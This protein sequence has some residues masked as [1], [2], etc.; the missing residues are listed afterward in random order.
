MVQHMAE[1]VPV[2]GE[3]DTAAIMRAA[4]DYI[5]GWN[6][7]DAARMERSLHPHLAKRIFTATSPTHWPPGDRLDETSAQHLIQMTRRNSVAAQPRRDSWSP[8][9]TV[10]ILDR[11]ANA[12]SVKIWGDSDGEYAHLARWNSQWLIVNVLWGLRL[13]EQ[14]PHV[15]LPAGGEADAIMHTARDYNEGWDEGD[16]ARM[17]RSLHP[18]LAKRTV[19][20]N[21]EPPGDR[22]DEMSALSLVQLTRREPTPVQDRVSTDV[23]ILDRVANAA[24][25][26]IG[27]TEYLDDYLHVALWNGRWVIVNVLWEPRP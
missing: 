2:Q 4:R 22:L 11:V 16:A 3:A 13:A 10:T 7:G 5:E 26:K 1:P 25:V 23:T 20:P 24:S 15:A 21:A 14:M 19:V 12:A 18:H 8:Q 6:D 27:T 9:T 17:E